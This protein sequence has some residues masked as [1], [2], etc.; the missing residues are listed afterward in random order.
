M[1]RAAIGFFVIG[2]LFF[3]IGAGNLGGLSMEVGRIILFVFLALAILSFLGSVFSGGKKN[4][5]IL[6]GLGHLS[7]G[8]PGLSRAEETVLENTKVKIIINKNDISQ[9]NGVSINN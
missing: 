4:L 1:L 3:A 8:N 7:L 9:V 5:I 2:I 6:L